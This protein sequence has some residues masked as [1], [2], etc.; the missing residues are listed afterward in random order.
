MKCIRKDIIIEN[1]QMDNIQLEKDILYTIDH[2]FLVNME[3]VFQN[4][5]RIYFLMHFVK[6]GELFRH[7]VAVKRFQEEQ[8]KFFAAQVALALAHLHSKKILYRDLK[9]ENVLVGDDGK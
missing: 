9:P 3:Y 5:F 4:E 6:G 7:L 1:E 8:A 2:P